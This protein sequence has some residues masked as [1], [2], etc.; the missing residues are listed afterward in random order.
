MDYEW[1]K[2]IA[3]IL[4]A[5]GAF[6]ASRPIHVRVGVRFAIKQGLKILWKYIQNYRLR[7]AQGTQEYKDIT[8]IAEAIEVLC[9]LAS[10]RLGINI[11]PKQLE[12]DYKT[13]GEKKI[14]KLE[15]KL[16]KKPSWRTGR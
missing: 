12:P 6:L 1:I 14:E 11:R 7:Y 4:V 9:R 8:E 13:R 2:W 3:G 16:N 15:K 5:V 10:E